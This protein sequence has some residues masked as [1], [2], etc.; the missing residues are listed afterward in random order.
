M[1]ATDPAAD[2]SLILQNHLFDQSSRTTTAPTFSL[3]PNESDAVRGSQNFELIGTIVAGKR[4]LAVLRSGQ[5]TV[6]YRLDEELP[7]GGTIEEITRHQV[8]IRNVNHT[9]TTLSMSYNFV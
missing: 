6:S 1:P 9:L 7:G 3:S 5:E 4:S 2:L 8:T